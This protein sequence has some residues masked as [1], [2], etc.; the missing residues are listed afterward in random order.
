M[1]VLKDEEF[2]SLYRFE[3]ARYGPADCELGH[4]YSHRHPDAVFINHLVVSLNLANETRSL[5][6]LEYR[7]ITRSGIQR[8]EISG[9]ENLRQILVEELG[10]N[11]TEAECC[12]LYGGL[13][14]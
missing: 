11:V 4:F 12:R 7:V 1:Q 6:D 9:Y 14:T 8:Q 2:F 10:V 3:L 5:C 13:N